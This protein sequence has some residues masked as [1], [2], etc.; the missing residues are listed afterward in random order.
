M[1]R[2][3]SQVELALAGWL[4]KSFRNMNLFLVARDQRR[5]KAALTDTVLHSQTATAC[6]RRPVRVFPRISAGNKII[7]FSLNCSTA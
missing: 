3:I 6:K 1:Y 4:G 5:L 2:S 7:T